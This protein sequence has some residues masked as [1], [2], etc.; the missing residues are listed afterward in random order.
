MGKA[1]LGTAVGGLVLMHQDGLTLSQSVSYYWDG[2]NKAGKAAT[3]AVG[4]SRWLVRRNAG[5]PDL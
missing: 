5:H 2:Q 3:V 1:A 4:C